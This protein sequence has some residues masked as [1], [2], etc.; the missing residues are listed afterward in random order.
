MAWWMPCAESGRWRD[1]VDRA[2]GADGLIDST[3]TGPKGGVTTVDRTR[4]PDGTV[5]RLVTSTAPAP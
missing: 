5:N 3:T 2:R 1:D 4:N